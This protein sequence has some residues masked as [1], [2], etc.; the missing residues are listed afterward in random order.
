MLSTLNSI[1][2]CFPM[3]S[4]LQLLGWYDRPIDV[5]KTDRTI[6][7]LTSIPSAAEFALSRSRA[8]SKPPK[9]L[10]LSWKSSFK[11]SRLVFSNRQQ[12]KD[13]DH[14]Q[15][16][17]EYGENVRV[18]EIKEEYCEN[19]RVKKEP[20]DQG[21]RPLLR[22]S[23][24]NKVGFSSEIKNTFKV[25]GR[26]ERRGWRRR[27]RSGEY[28]EEDFTPRVKEE[29]PEDAGGSEE[30]GYATGFEVDEVQMAD[31]N[32]GEGTTGAQEVET[33]S[34]DEAEDVAVEVTDKGAAH[35][36]QREEGE[37]EQG[38]GV[39]GR[40]K[41]ITKRIVARLREHMASSLLDKLKEEVVEDVVGATGQVWQEEGGQRDQE[42]EQAIVG[43][44]A[45][46]E[47]GDNEMLD[48][49]IVT[50]LKERERRCEEEGERELLRIAAHL[51][52]CK[53]C[54]DCDD[55]RLHGK[56]CN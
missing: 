49:M 38:P 15:I 24:Q 8:C 45:E 52:K 47:H 7:R 1:T 39:Q 28:D 35:Q 34:S 31:L 54:D 3:K 6:V 10:V 16:K 17:E 27:R 9:L 12:T 33:E 18:K 51:I 29:N 19:V 56:D 5:K 22:V 55:D 50:L 20:V 43:L 14:P 25:M 37:G 13:M 21:V 23:V 26:D 36:G 46:V 42:V 4:D 2:Q 40:Y 11:L 53:G 32:V 30:A 41:D 48:K 44:E